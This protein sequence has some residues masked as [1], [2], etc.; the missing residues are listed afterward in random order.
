MKEY[1]CT[2]NKC[3]N[4]NKVTNTNKV[5]QKGTYKILDGKRCPVYNYKCSLCGRYVAHKDVV[6]YISF[7]SM[8]FNG[9]KLL[10][11]EEDPYEFKGYKILD[12]GEIVFSYGCY[13]YIQ[14][15]ENKFIVFTGGSSSGDS[16]L[17]VEV[18]ELEN[19]D[20]K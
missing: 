10:R 1:Y 20:K 6:Y 11:T 8:Y 7:G 12:M 9:I 17:D 15:K 13:Y 14:I 19:K 3:K 2:N 18:Y 5:L 4:F 16:F